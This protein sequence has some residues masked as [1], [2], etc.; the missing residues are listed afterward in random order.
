ML[1][2]ILIGEILVSFEAHEL[3]CQ[4]TQHNVLPR[5]E[6][7]IQCSVLICLEMAM[8]S[9]GNVHNIIIGFPFRVPNYTHFMILWHGVKQI[10]AHTCTWRKWV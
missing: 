8:V 1:I 7:K 5:L 2:N 10:V 4:S 9:Q 6:A 3:L